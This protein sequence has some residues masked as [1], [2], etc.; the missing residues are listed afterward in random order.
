MRHRA[1]CFLACVLLSA[2]V[3]EPPAD[4]VGVT[5]APIVDGE[6]P[7]GRYPGVVFLYNLAGAACTATIVAPRAVLTA[8]HCVQGR[9]DVAAPAGQFRIYAGDSTRSFYQEYRVQEVRVPPGC[10]DLCGDA[11]DVAMLI[12]TAPADEEPIPVSFDPPRDIRGSPFTAIGYGETPAGRAGTKYLTMK[13]IEQIMGGIIFVEPSV[14]SGDSGGPIIG[15]DGAIYGVA[16][17]IYSPDG[18]SEPRCG[19]APG[20]YNGIQYL[21][22]FIEQ[23]ITD[24][25]SCVPEGE[26]ICDGVDNDCNDVIDE[27]CSPIGT[28]CTAGDECVGGV[29][30]MTSAGRICTQTCDPLRPELGCGPGLYCA[31]A[32]GCDGYC[33]PVGAPPATPLGYGA[34]C[35]TDTDCQSLFCIDPGDGRR[36]CLTPC[37]GDAGMCI[38]G[39]ACAAPTGACGGCV[40][41]GIVGGL[42]GR[43]EPCSMDSECTSG[44]CFDD[45]GVSY[46]SLACTDDTECGERFHCR[47]MHCALGARGST[48]AGCVNN[49]DCGTDFLCAT[50]GDARWCTAFCT[51]DPSVCPTGFECTPVGDVSVCAPAAGLAGEA[52]TAGTDCV[53]GLCVDP[54]GGSV[55]TEFCG[56]DR[57]CAP[58][59]DCIR[60]ADGIN[61]VCV[62]HAAPPGDGGGGCSVGRASSRGPGSALG[63]V[64]LG[65]ALAWVHRRR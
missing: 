61:S 8:K 59:F 28:P 27:G 62:S 33:A 56:A 3:G 30:E 24:S 7:V 51:A 2:C 14:C 42:R 31:H 1:A 43:G 45:E 44:V 21:Q 18:R 10:W 15:S 36:R 41:A 9:G 38:T 5:S 47:D 34:D 57:A 46:C 53:S 12:L 17:F 32:T 40:P 64:L 23:A 37:R 25:G 48:G 65:L 19:T 50:R 26:E 54:G 52:C 35:S 22:D 29:C 13:S 58:G 55:C 63:L 60:T 11:S 49:A 16:S 6:A 20:A 39:E 4:P